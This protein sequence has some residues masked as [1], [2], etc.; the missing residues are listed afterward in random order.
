MAAHEGDAL[1]RKQYLAIAREWSAMVEKA[2]PAPKR[3]GSRFSTRQLGQQQ[4]R[5]SRA[6][7]ATSCN[8]SA[9]IRSRTPACL[10]GRRVHVVPMALFEAHEPV[11]RIVSFQD[12]TAI[13]AGRCRALGAPRLVNGPA[14]AIM[15]VQCVEYLASRPE[16]LK[17]FWICP[18]QSFYRQGDVADAARKRQRV[19]Q[20]EGPFE[21][22]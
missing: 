3:T 18:H 5:S 22:K 16:P 21:Q 17:P 20:A 2:D 12:H 11:Q 9:G 8:A 1:L 15:Q 10:S 19:D 14:Q 6:K 4:M 13:Q 7:R